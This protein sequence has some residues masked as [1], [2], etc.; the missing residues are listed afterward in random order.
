MIFISIASL[1]VLAIKLILNKL[2]FDGGI[3]GF[4]GSVDK[5]KFAFLEITQEHIKTVAELPFIHRDPFDRIIIAQAM[6]EGMV[7]ATTDEHIIKYD[8]SYIW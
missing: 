2:E 1:W 4:I 6:V 3:D 7:V 5:N 8:I